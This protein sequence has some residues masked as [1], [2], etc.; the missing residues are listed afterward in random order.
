MDFTEIER[1][2]LK[3]LH[4]Y[5]ETLQNKIIP[6]IPIEKLTED[7]LDLEIE[8]DKLQDGVAG[9]L[10]IKD[11]IIVL[12][13]DDIPERQRFTI[14][15][16]IGHLSLHAK[17]LQVR[18]MIC[19]KNDKSRIEKEANYFAASILMPKRMV[20]ECLITN[21]KKQE[22][23]DMDWLSGVL[24]NL[25][26]TGLDSLNKLIFDYAKPSNSQIGNTE[27]GEMLLALISNISKQFLVSKEALTW[28]FKNVGLLDGF[29][30]PEVK[31]VIDKYK[32]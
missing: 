29:L 26:D 16:E 5:S 30:A 7:L 8:K 21:I 31:E 14:A 18:S 24:K 17:T 15:H 22:K 3:T 20:Y 28:R 13:A 27:N 9:I 4:K 6:P 19:R 25:P 2:A 12:N 32:S 1:I 23:L 10:Y 11:K